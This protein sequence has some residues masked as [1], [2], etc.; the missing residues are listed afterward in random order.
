MKYT[1]FPEELVVTTNGESG[2]DQCLLTYD[3]VEDA[4]VEGCYELVATYK[5][6]KVETVEC[7]FKYKRTKAKNVIEGNG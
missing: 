4:V 1:K 6:V 3:N 5:L 2:E 7:D